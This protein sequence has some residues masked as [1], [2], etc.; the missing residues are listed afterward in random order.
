MSSVCVH[1]LLPGPLPFS[2]A[3]ARVDPS[4]T[5]RA[6]RR[7]TRCLSISFTPRSC[8]ARSSFT[9]S[10]GA[11]LRAARR[12]PALPE[13][14]PCFARSL[15]VALLFPKNTLISRISG[16]FALA[17]C[18]LSR[19]P[20][21]PP[22]LCCTQVTPH[23]LAFRWSWSTRPRPHGTLAGI[24]PPT[25][26]ASHICSRP[27]PPSPARPKRPSAHTRHRWPLV[28]HRRTVPTPLR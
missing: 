4:P 22:T 28:S 1:Y 18:H 7:H 21:T 12:R 6:W 3:G 5:L 2:G 10:W 9:S 24:E 17:S 13:K 20:F 27:T 23:A 14:A 19:R 16:A 26:F 15:S 8:I 11:P 25:W